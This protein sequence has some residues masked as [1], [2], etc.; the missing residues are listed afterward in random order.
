MGAGISAYSL[1]THENLLSLTFAD[2]T[3]IFISKAIYSCKV[4]LKVD[5]YVDSSP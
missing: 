2:F 1:I 5:A 4:N 3:V